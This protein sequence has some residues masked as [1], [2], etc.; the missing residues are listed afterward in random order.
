MFNYRS[1]TFA[2]GCFVLHVIKIIWA[3]T[4]LNQQ[5]EC[6]SSEDSDQP[7][8]PPSLNQSL[9]CPHEESLGPFLT[10]ERTAKT[11]IRLGGCPGWSAS[12]LGAHSLCWFCHVVAQLCWLYIVHSTQCICCL[13]KFYE[14]CCQF[15]MLIFESLNRILRFTHY[16]FNVTYE[17]LSWCV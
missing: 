1:I 10:I 2:A 5:S 3:T 8:H 4:W 6:A 16:H 11:L 9:R 14:T 13:L 15:Q 17:A 7:G 12:S